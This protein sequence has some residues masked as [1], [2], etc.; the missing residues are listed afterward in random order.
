[1]Y[2][3]LLQSVKELQRDLASKSCELSATQLDLHSWKRKAAVERLRLVSVQE[4]LSHQKIQIE[5]LTAECNRHQEEYNVAQANFQAANAHNKQLAS[6]LSQ[7]A[8]V[9]TKLQVSP[10]VST[11][12]L[13]NVQR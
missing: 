2:I 10:T 3:C 4:D 5:A 11:A 1:M 6:E 7:T 12:T 13:S 9:S 8:A